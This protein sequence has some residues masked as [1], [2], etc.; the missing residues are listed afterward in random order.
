MTRMERPDEAFQVKFRASAFSVGPG[1]YLEWITSRT[2]D[3]LGHHMMGQ[4]VVS[5]V[6]LFRDLLRDSAEGRFKGLHFQAWN[7]I[8]FA[9]DYFIEVNDRIEDTKAEGLTDD[10]VVLRRM[11][12]RFNSCIEEYLRWR[13]SRP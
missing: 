1:A 9:L 13:S 3:I 6:Y 7:Q 12:G 10:L 4:E 5:D 2:N 8:A 11:R